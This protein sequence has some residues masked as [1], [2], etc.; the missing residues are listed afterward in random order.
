[1]GVSVEDVMVAIDA[2][3]LKARKIGSATRIAKSALE[4]FLRG[5]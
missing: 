5:E 2:G 4:A 1:M 3:D